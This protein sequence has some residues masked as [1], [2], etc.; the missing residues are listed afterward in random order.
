MSRVA[1]AYERKDLDF[2]PTKRWVFHAL[3]EVVPFAGR[4]AW[5]MACG[6]GEGCEALKECG[7][8]VVVASDIHNYGYAPAKHYD[9]LEGG[10]P[11]YRVKPDI[12]VTN[13]P[14]GERCTL[15]EKFIERGLG[16]IG[17]NGGTLCLLL[18]VDFDSASTRARFFRDC[19][20]FLGTIVL[21]RRIKWFD[22]PVPCRPC[23]ATGSIDGVKCKSC[24]GKGEK[25]VGPSENH[26]WFLWS[27]PSPG[28]VLHPQK[29]Y[30]PKA[31]A[32]AAEEAA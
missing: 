20:M 28:Q 16:W 18:P 29:F 8:K 19:P 23:K 26:C 30:A 4:I 1:S 5:E 31:A 12:L 21:T 27:R 15:A 11:P 17:A 22:G 25:K 7:A 13:P 14:Y 32:E 6:N 9:F 24:G 2:Y 10:T 3:N